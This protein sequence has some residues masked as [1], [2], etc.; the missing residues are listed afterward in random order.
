MSQMWT[1][2]KLALAAR[3]YR[4]GTVPKA[5]SQEIGVPLA[6]LMEVVNRRA[7]LF[8]GA[9][10]VI[11]E[12]VTA[13]QVQ[14]KSRDRSEHLAKQRAFHLADPAPL[15]VGYEPGIERYRQAA[16]GAGPVRMERLTS[17]HCKWPVSGEK[18]ETLFCGD[19]ALPGRSWCACHAARATARAV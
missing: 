13:P 6:R 2:E 12:P 4:L 18:A 19:A 10:R 7:D 9:G 11:A 8:G 15:R 1:R 3:L 17:R 14:A 16:P 5:I